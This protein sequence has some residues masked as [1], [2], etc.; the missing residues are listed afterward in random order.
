M[1]G[2]AAEEAGG[3]VAAQTEDTE[4]AVATT[5][6]IRLLM[7]RQSLV[8]INVNI[9]SNLATGAVNAKIVPRRKRLT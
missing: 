1:M 4:M 6:V 2:R 3:V 7:D 8:R 9:V 5:Q